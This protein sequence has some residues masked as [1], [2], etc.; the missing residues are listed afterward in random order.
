MKAK[1]I[2]FEKLM[3]PL[4]AQLKYDGVRLITKIE[5]NMPK[6]Y[7]YN[8]NQVPLPKLRDKLLAAKLGCIMLDGEIVTQGG[9]VGTRPMV[10][11][12]INSAMHGGRIN[13]NI[14][15]YA[16]FDS[17]HLDDF[18]FRKC[19]ID[20]QDRYAKTA[21]YALKAEITVARNTMMYKTA[22]VQELSEHMYSD[23]FEG[24]ILKPLLHPY[25]FSRSPHWVK[26]KE[27]KTADLYCTGT[28]EG[29]GKY[30]GMIGALKLEGIVEGHDISVKAGSGMNDNQ[31]ASSP[32]CYL[33][34]TIEVKYNSVI[35]DQRTGEWSLFLP[36]FN[37]IRIDK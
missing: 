32:Y 37:G 27:T 18:D 31:R 21:I 11:G 17:M 10:S 26:I 25:R 2:P 5:D 8:G 6:F 7:T 24:L 4:L 15:D 29:T 16:V 9:R 1:E 33:Y 13:E 28:T 19:A 12:M 22:D 34:R 35:Q 3:F 14:L 23:G 36:R 30:E 20:Y